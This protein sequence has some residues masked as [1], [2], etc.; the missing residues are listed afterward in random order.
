MPTIVQV[1]RKYSITLRKSNH[2]VGS[3]EGVVSQLHLRH[4]E[5]VMEGRL[6]ISAEGVKIDDEMMF[7][8]EA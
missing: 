3:F 8:P 7:R 6:V 2:A 4:C 1:L 5:F